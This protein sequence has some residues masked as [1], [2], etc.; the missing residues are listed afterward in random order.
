MSKVLLSS[1][2][3]ALSTTCMFLPAELLFLVPFYDLAKIKE[4]KQKMASN[5]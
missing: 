1:Q 2:K 4:I 5:V 3:A